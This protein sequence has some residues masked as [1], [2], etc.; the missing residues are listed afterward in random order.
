MSMNRR[1]FLATGIAGGVALGTP[2]ILGA[3]KN[4]KYKTALIGS[5]WWGMNI[6]NEAIAAGES[7]VVALCDVDEKRAAPTYQRFPHAKIYKDFRKALEELE[8]KYDAVVI[9]TPD[10]T[11]APA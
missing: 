5:G 3:Q 9:S 2:A 8:P 7:D 6:L 11:H 1:R 10:H 4:K